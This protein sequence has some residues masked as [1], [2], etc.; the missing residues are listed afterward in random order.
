MTDRAT[1]GRILR[2]LTVTPIGSAGVLVGSSSLLGFETNVPALTEDVDICVPSELVE[3]EGDAIVASL[4]AHGWAHEDGTATF[5]SSDGVT[6]D[7]LGH[8]DPRKGD[9]IAGSGR[10]RVMVFE[11]LSRLLGSSCAT[12]PVTPLGRVLTPAA[13]VASKLLTERSHKGAKDKLQALLVIA[14]HEGD[15]TFRMRLRELFAEVDEVRREDARASALEAFL[16]LGQDPAFADAG[17]EGYLAYLRDA[18][19]GLE[20]L[21]SLLDGLH[22]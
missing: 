18:R 17:A 8:D 20:R 22:A 4:D 6:F 13:F 14:E 15:T 7:L 5:V 11:D 1:A 21:Q 19:V 10:L 12:Q 16:A 9:H 3:R 2:L